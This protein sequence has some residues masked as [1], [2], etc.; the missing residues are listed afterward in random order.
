MTTDRTSRS[1][2]PVVTIAPPVL[3]DAVEGFVSQNWNAGVTPWP[4]CDKDHVGAVLIIVDEGQRAADAD[5]LHTGHPLLNGQAAEV[6]HWISNKVPIVIIHKASQ[7]DHQL[8]ALEQQHRQVRY[9]I[10]KDMGWYEIVY[11]ALRSIQAC[12]RDNLPMQIA[13]TLSEHRAHKRAHE[14]TTA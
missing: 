5:L 6:K 1:L 3:M 2:L 11:H 14:L 8:E 13:L 4:I 12:H 9:Q 10:F 7:R